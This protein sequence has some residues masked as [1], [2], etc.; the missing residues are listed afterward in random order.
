MI[1]EIEAILLGVITFLHGII[2]FCLIILIW[3]L[4]PWWGKG[5]P[6]QPKGWED[7]ELFH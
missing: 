3:Q 7:E 6:E 5:K 1:C 2:A 4:W